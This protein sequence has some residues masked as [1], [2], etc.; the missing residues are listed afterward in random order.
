MFLFHQCKT[1]TTQET[2]LH[3]DDALQTRAQMRARLAYYTR[4]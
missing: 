4:V 2:L 3:E 1:T